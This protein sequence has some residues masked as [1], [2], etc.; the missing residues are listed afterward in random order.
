MNATALLAIQHWNLDRQLACLEGHVKSG[1]RAFA[2][3]VAEELIAHLA[4]EKNV[5]YPLAEEIGGRTL[6]EEREAHTAVFR[7]LKGALLV[8][9]DEDMFEERLRA[10][11][12][13]FDD[14]ATLDERA[15]HAVL[16]EL[17]LREL[18][19]VGARMQDFYDACLRARRG[20]ADAA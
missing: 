14:H 5:F 7:C 3:P 16:A 11:R 13:A 17:S 6:A 15:V 20:A 8:L 1:R 9:D 18:S 4:M 10:L 19:A 12:D 2:I